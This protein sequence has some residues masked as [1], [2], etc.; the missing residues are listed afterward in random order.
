MPGDHI[1]P[2]STFRCHRSRVKKLAM[3]P[4]RREVFLSASEDG[5]VRQFDLRQHHRCNIVE[6]QRSHAYYVLQHRLPRTD[7]CTDTMLVN[8]NIGSE[9][10]ELYWYAHHFPA[11][12][13][14]H[15]GCL[16]SFRWNV[17]AHGCQC[18][19]ERAESRV[20]CNGGR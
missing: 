3:D 16:C 8:T 17:C 9:R 13:L 11:M 14:Q 6:P 15:E 19:D 20:L 7:T 4:L 12:M 1:T 18:D 2:L 5:S 10:V